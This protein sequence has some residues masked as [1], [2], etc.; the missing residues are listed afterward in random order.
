[1]DRPRAHSSPHLVSSPSSN[2]AE[3]PQPQEDCN[4]EG[5]TTNVRLLLKLIQDHNGASMKENEER[6]VHRVNGI[7]SILDEVRS[8]IQ[9]I[10]TSTKKKAE[11]RRCNT[12]LR[13]TIPTSNDKRQPD[14]PI[15]EKERLRRELNAS[16]MARQSLQAMCASLGKEKQIMASELARKAQEL[17][18][19]EELLVDLKT[20]NNMLAEKLYACSSEKKSNDAEIEG[21]IALQERNRALTEQLHKSL[22]AYRSLKHKYKDAREENQEIHATLEQLKEE[23]EAGTQRIHGFKEQVIKSHEN[24]FAEE[25]SAIENML[26]SLSLKISKHDQEKT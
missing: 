9:R 10:Q 5:I 13:P 26:E 7:M 4:L 19:M 17:A 18:E 14:L 2:N 12:D 1:M 25:I 20:Q 21:N 3:R 15:D 11:L 24:I 22:D 6:K 23:V 16:F 8:R